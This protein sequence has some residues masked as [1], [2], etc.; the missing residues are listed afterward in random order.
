[1]V[2]DEVVSMLRSRFDTHSPKTG[3]KPRVVFW[4]D[5]PGEFSG[6]IDD[7][8]L[9]DIRIIRWDGYNCFLIKYT[10][11]HVDRD[12][13]FLIYVQG[14]VPGDEENILADM[15]HYSEPFFSADKASCI[16][17]E[18][19]V[20]EHHV[21][22]IREHTAFFNSIDRRRRFS[23][24][25]FDTDDPSELRSSM[26]AAVLNAD[27][28][29]V[30]DIMSSVFKLF[31]ESPGGDGEEE[32]LSLL[33]KYDL[34][35]HLWGICRKEFGYE[36][37]S[38]DI[39][40][41]SLI[42][43]AA[44]H[45]SVVSG[46]PK[47][48]KY[49]LPKGLTIHSMVTRILNDPS[50]AESMDS[51]VQW[52]SDKVGLSDILDAYDDS[53]LIDVGIFRDVDDVLVSRSMRQLCSTCSSLDGSSESLIR[54]RLT[55]NRDDD[56]GSRYGMLL[57]ASAIMEACSEFRNIFIN[58]MSPTEIIDNYVGKWHRIDTEYRHFIRDSDRMDSEE[59]QELT[60]LV[61]NTYTNVFVDPVIR[62]LC[63]K[64]GSYTDLPGPAQTG[65]CR[66]HLDRSQKTVVIISDAFRYEC[67]SELSERMGRTSRIRDRRLDHMI[68]TVPSIT[69]F[70]MAALLPNDGLEISRDGRYD[71]L[72]KGHSTA[73][74]S[75]ET[76]LSSTYSDSIVLTY[77]QVKNHGKETRELCKGKGL[78]YIYHDVVDAT[79]DSFK[80]EDRVFD[81]C[82]TAMDEIMD[83][84]RIV[85]NWSYHRFIITSDH[86]FLY[87][88]S[89]VEE[90]DKISA[91]DGSNTG[92]RYALHDQPFGLERTVEFSLEYLDGSNTDL[93][94]STPDS[95]S[96]FKKQGG[97]LNFV[98]GGISPQE[99]VVPV[100]T[101][102]TV[103]GAIVEKYV[104]LKSGGKA[105]IK[106][107]SPTFT[108]LQENAVSN[109]FREAEYEIWI[110]DM[111]GRRI[112]S[113]KI[114]VADS[115][116]PSDM[117]HRVRFDVEL[118]V[119]TVRLI[120]CNRTSSDEPEKSIEF[121]VNMLYD[122]YI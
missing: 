34:T 15:M 70:G 24:L 88:R 47:L 83:M 68:S 66:S 110:E 77:D 112:T 113:S 44:V 14:E 84:V 18:L 60:T 36:G 97:G 35:D 98:H 89:P 31:S 75:R 16:A 117:K 116:D 72:I 65:F 111:D 106:Q 99:I 69:S 78:V 85:T 90:Y 23:R 64:V 76:I 87:R 48:S 96:L 30:M 11:E 114:V 8:D 10:V 5:V 33:D 28:S 39:L 93:Y 37:E 103:K 25:C 45:S 118:K 102:N 74:G 6:S 100:L 32:V 62:A 22:I 94:V 67:A 79:G 80:T 21:D 119:K 61:E 1:M 41:R 120:I 7:L 50:D 4:K 63:S 52:V 86:G 109:E 19:G 121:A 95:I 54:N 104:G 91:Q 40:I 81:A 73:A 43:T 107:K 122:N 13:R 46:S 56:M 53:E 3:M 27:T 49:I 57:S 108:L 55:S 58:D 20:P 42:V 92:R 71:V 51:L 17:V 26:I 12:S 38:I 101:V 29:S 82:E 115:S 59:T 105:A 2:D 9:G